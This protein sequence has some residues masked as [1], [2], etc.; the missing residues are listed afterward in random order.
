MELRYCEKHCQMTNHEHIKNSLMDVWSC[1]KCESE[2]EQE[3]F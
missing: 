3:A 1:L 2:E